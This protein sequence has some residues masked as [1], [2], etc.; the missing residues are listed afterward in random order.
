MINNL[1]ILAAPVQGITDRHWR[2][3][4]NEIFGGVDGYYSPFMRIER[5]EM[6][7]RDL[8]DVNPA[9]NTVSHFTPQVLA[10]QPQ[11]AVKMVG[12]LKEMG[13]NEIDINL[14]CPFPP[15]ALHHKGSGLLQYPAEVEAMLNALATIE[16]I[17]YS[18]KMRLGWDNPGQWRLILPLMEIIN[19]QHITIH[20]RTGRQQYKGAL[21]LD[22]FSAI[23]K[24][25]HYPLVYNG[26]VK[27][28]DDID[29]I[30]EQFPEV[31]A[32]MIGR[33][34]IE[35]PAMLCPEKALAANYRE[36]H[37]RLLAAY[38]SQLNGGEHQLLT[39]MKSLWDYFL[40]T[41]PR[42]ALKAIKKATSM[43]KY[44]TAV[45]ELFLSL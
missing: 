25:C 4:H 5:G 22:G 11:D 42:K 7:K 13:Y 15:I 27:T 9:S 3:A 37:S 39:K 43:A 26:G 17:S 8:A 28:L 36:F 44:N 38:E 24:E 10:C 31:K 29:K 34:L 23:L 6:R 1:K 21:D 33:G 19:P 18:V 45:S 14:G 16:G 40:P 41:A 35:D 32:V 12:T 20:P 2:N 30:N